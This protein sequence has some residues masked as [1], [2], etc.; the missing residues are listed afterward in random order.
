[1]K[2]RKER[3]REKGATKR[4]AHKESRKR[5]EGKSGTEKNTQKEKKE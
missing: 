4:H 2:L 5:R 1:V 3:E